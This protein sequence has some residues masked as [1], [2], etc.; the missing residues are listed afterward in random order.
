[1]RA[2][3][4]RVTRGRY[5]PTA[6]ACVLRLVTLGY[7]RD[8]DRFERWRR[9]APASTRVDTP[10]IARPIRSRTR[11]PLPERLAPPG[12]TVLALPLPAVEAHRHGFRGLAHDLLS[13]SVPGWLW[14]LDLD[15][16][17]DAIACA[18]H[19][20]SLRDDAFEVLEEVP[21]EPPV[22]MVRMRGKERGNL[23]ALVV[24]RYAR[25]PPE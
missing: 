13:C 12:A 3:V 6:D 14:T 1:M 5:T 24:V 7:Q 21:G 25:V 20:A 4:R 2:A 11:A 15:A 10:P 22:V 9:G 18:R 19:Q 8:P 23:F 17:R 16:G